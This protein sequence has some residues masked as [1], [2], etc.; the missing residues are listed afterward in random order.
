MTETLSSDEVL[1][2]RVTA[3]G[4]GDSIEKDQPSTPADS[5]SGATPTGPERIAN[6]ARGMLAVQGQDW[7][8]ARWALGLR[9]P[10]T[11]VGDVHEAFNTGLIVRSWP[12]RGTI[13]LLAAEDIGWMQGVTNRRVI[14]G[15]AKRR[16]FLG[17]TDET[18]ELLVSTSVAA[19]RGGVSM[20]RDELAAAW[21]AAGIA[22]QGNWRYH[23]IWWLCQNG[24]TV[25]GPVSENGEPRLVLASEWITAPRTL[26]GDEA[27]TELAARYASARGVVTAADLG[28]WAGI[29]AGEAKRGL[30][31]AEAA[32]RLAQLSVRRGEKPVAVWADPTLLETASNA[33]LPDWLLLP[34][35]DEH[36]LGYQDRSA[37][38]DPDHFERIVPGRNGMFLATVVRDGRVVGTWKK[39][40]RKGEGLVGTPLPGERLGAGRTALKR[41]ASRWAAFHDL[42]ESPFTIAAA[43]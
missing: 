11:H 2:L 29:T 36:L 26:D 3:Q 16:E 43:D 27:L 33:A 21:S 23:L 25:L 18:L 24:Y 17:I 31:G 35:F 12:M 13:H 38:L 5:R 28:W 32:G 41:Q 40:T 14:A 42:G 9:T 15:A 4:L 10:G 8:S 1:R 6:T 22:W 39:G 37:Q 20:D 34:A 30:T 19:L 7:R